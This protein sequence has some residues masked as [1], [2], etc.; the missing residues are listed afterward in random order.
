MG[1]S[2]GHLQ[3][4][5]FTP[6]IERNT[7]LPV[8]KSEHFYTL[9]DGQKAVD[10]RIYQGE[11]KL[12]KDNQFVGNFII[13][14][15]SDVP[16]GNELNLDLNL[17]IDGL[18]HVTAAETL[19]GLSKTVRMETDHRM[20]LLDPEAAHQDLFEFIRRNKLDETGEDQP[21]CKHINKIV[22]DTNHLINRASALLQEVDS[23]DAKELID[24][25]DKS[26]DAISRQALEQLA[27]LNESLE[28]MLFYL[29]D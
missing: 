26:K 17:D 7:P 25:I 23:S 29:E 8:K 12:T 14:G 4:G 21:G 10:V 6:I 28:D 15:L 16:A 1:I 19:T 2:D 20:D 3:S 24:L 22:N 5:I 11:E 18:L 13:E 27:V 9:T